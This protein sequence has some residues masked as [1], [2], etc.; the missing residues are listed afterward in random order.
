M[1]RTYG[2]TEYMFYTI[3]ENWSA[4]FSW[5]ETKIILYEAD[6]RPGIVFYVEPGTPQPDWFVENEY[7]YETNEDHVGY[8]E[9][10]AR[11]MAGS[12]Y[13]KR[14]VC[15]EYEKILDR[16]MASGY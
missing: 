16:L 10:H 2:P 6:D 9:A 3:D 15:A 11:L 8:E 13:Q 14:R 12:R 7:V 1:D 5:K 4:A